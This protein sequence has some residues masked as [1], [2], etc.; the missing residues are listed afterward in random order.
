MGSFDAYTTLGYEKITP[1]TATGLTVPEGA[2]GAFI[3][4]D[5]ANVRWRDDGSDPDASTGQ[6]I[7]KDLAAE[8]FIGKL[9]TTKLIKESGTAHVNVVYVR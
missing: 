1:D 4:V 6:R 9:S 8:R 2:R 7:I 3:T 5:G